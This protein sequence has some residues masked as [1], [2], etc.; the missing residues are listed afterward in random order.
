MEQ[1]KLTLPDNITVTGRHSL[2][3]QS[4]ATPK[5]LPLIVAL[6]GGTYSSSYFDVDN[7]H[8]PTIASTG[9]GVPFVA[10]D[11]PGYQGTLPIVPV[12]KNTTYAE[13]YGRI[14]H[15]YI[16]PSLWSTFGAPH[17]SSSVVLHCHSLGATGAVVAAGLHAAEPANS[18]QYSLA[19]LSVSGFGLVPTGPPPFQPGLDPKNL[20][21]HIRFPN[22]VKDTKMTPPGLV[23]PNIYKYT[24]R[25][26]HDIALEELTQLQPDFIPKWKKL[27]GS[28]K[29]PVMIVFA[30]HDLL[31]TGVERLLPEFMAAFH[32]SERVDGSII[33]G[34]P[35]NIGM[36][37]WAQGYYARVFGYAIECATSLGQKN[38]S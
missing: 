23:D 25:L 36:S 8:T 28:V 22:D 31:W 38:K 16:L 13:E 6:H 18:V 9:L 33:K 17:G 35:H 5:Y 27:V 20:P 12:P 7:T 34:A 14:L 24:E 21:T 2:P 3:K 37:Y 30:E 1:F 4:S 32:G 19:G 11:R 10:I 26:N 29:A 15:H